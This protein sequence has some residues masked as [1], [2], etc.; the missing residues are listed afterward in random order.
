[1]YSNS[2]ITELP[3]SPANIVGTAIPN[4]INEQNN[5][6][7]NSVSIDTNPNSEEHFCAR[8]GLPQR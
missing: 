4:R 1:M 7:D 8:A 3:L 2:N 6:P 5:N